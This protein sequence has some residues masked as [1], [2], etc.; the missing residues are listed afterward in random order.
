MYRRLNDAP[1]DSRCN[2][3]VEQQND[4]LHV[5]LTYPDSPETTLRYVVVNQESERDSAGVRVW[6]DY[7]R[8]GHVI[9]AGGEGGWRE[10]AFA[11]FDPD[12]ET[13]APL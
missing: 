1:Y 13:V 8:G 4:T 5:E 7:K 12:Q 6:P 3:H 9:E 2:T 11:A 10:I